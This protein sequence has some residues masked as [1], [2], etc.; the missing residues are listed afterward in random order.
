[1]TEAKKTDVGG[2]P[3]EGKIT[4]AAIEAARGMI[5]LQLAPGRPLSPGRNV[6][7][8]AEFLQWHRRSQSALSRA[9]N[10][11]ANTRLRHPGRPSDVSNGVR[12]GW[13]HA[14]GTAGRPRLL[15]RKRLGAV[16]PYPPRRPDQR[17]RACRGRRGKGEQVL[18]APGSAIR[19]GDLFS[20]QRG[21]IVARA[22]SGTCTRHERKAARDT[23]KYKDIK[24]YDYT[25]EE[26]EQLDEAILREVNERIRA[27][28]T[29]AT[30]R[31]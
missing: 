15:R 17:D 26:F 6:R 3:A 12:L 21:E 27:A 31:T 11:A 30:G 23:G 4:D 18:R 20:N 2:A 1:M 9:R 16:P 8:D 13:P 29:S 28:A 7:H 24:P 10:T 14:M 25:P 22:Q 5:G 19:R